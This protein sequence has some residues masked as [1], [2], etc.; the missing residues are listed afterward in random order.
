MKQ[1]IIAIIGQAGAGKDTVAQMMRM[2]LGVPLLCSFT[3][4]PMREGEENGR[5]HYFVKEC[6]TPKENMLAYTE[7][8]GYKYWTELSQI[9]DIAIYVID[10]RGLIDI[11]EKF[12]DIDITSIY[13]AAK[14]QTLKARGIDPERMKR[15]EYRVKIDVNNYDYVITNNSSLYALLQAVISVAM[16]ITKYSQ[17]EPEIE[18]KMLS[19]YMKTALEHS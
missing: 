5:E 2:T 19:E 10:E 17:N 8:G 16:Q 9:E 6:N 7:Y 3:T 15:D 11:M 12:P 18:N 14:P 13:I 1:K 4:R